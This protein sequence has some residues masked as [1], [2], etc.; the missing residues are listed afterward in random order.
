MR[1][2]LVR[3]LSLDNKDGFNFLFYT[4][5]EPFRLRLEEIERPCLRLGSGTKT[6]NEEK[7]VVH[8]HGRFHRVR[9][10][11]LSSL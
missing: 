1:S 5:L 4:S 8:Q 7:T 11:F 2:N 10:F 9:M 6:A 3:H